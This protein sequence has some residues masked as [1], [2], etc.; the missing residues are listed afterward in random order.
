[1]NQPSVGTSSYASNRHDEAQNLPS[2]ITDRRCS[3]C[4]P[5][6]LH[7]LIPVANVGLQLAALNVYPVFVLA[8][9]HSHDSFS[10]AGDQ[11]VIVRQYLW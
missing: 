4:C 9:S 7:H 11:P 2:A 5:L 10:C 1:M 8:F 3:D 6:C